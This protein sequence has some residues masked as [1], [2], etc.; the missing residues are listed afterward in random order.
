MS[1][2]ANVSVFESHVDNRNSSGF[3]N[4]TT[5]AF[6]LTY[7]IVFGSRELWMYRKHGTPHSSN[8]LPKSKLYLLQ[9]LVT[10]IPCLLAIIRFFVQ[11]NYVHNGQD[12][13]FLVK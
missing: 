12:Y 9:Q 1:C 6:L 4:P 8:N 10:Y 2:P 3:V 13:G 7:L 11:L 5:S